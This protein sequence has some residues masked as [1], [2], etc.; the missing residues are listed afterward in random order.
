MRIQARYMF[1]QAYLAAILLALLTIC[2]SARA[3]NCEEGLLNAD[4]KAALHQALVE[5]YSLEVLSKIVNG[6][7]R[8]VVLLGEAHIKNCMA[9]TYGKDVVNCFDHAAVESSKFDATLASR[10]L[11]RIVKITYQ[12]AEW[13]GFEGSTIKY[14]RDV[15]GR[16]K[17]LK[18][19]AVRARAFGFRSDSP[20]I[21]DFLERIDW[22][23]RVIRPSRLRELLKG[24][25][26]SGE[27]PT[28]MIQPPTF[29]ELDHVM[30]PRE[31][32]GVSVILSNMAFQ[33]SMAAAKVGA[34]CTGLY[35]LAVNGELFSDAWKVLGGAMALSATAN[36][37][38]ARA[39]LARYMSDTLCVGRDKTMADNLQ[40]LLG[41]RDDVRQ[42][43]V[44]VG[45]AHVP[46][47]TQ[48]LV[49]SGFTKTDNPQA[50]LR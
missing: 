6:R 14:V 46:G 45:M 23:E 29:L 31:R 44:I 16:K 12:A 41:S 27:V 48:H 15:E 2:D 4:Q 8:T 43:L 47:I 9:A 33:T 18:D 36:F 50:L 22:Q 7:A 21:D 37:I 32:E 35:G 38:L 19:L 42:V 49:G 11:S 28:T 3:H 10:I 17:V 1:C 20:A 26:E 40:A 25:E 39:G 30:S 24:M 13:V 34:L 5:E